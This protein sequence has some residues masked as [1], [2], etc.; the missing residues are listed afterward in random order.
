MERAGLGREPRAP[1][2]MWGPPA[3]GPMEAWPWQA[4]A[5]ATTYWGQGLGQ[6]D[7]TP[8]TTR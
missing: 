4:G 2:A 3:A 5:L 1:V 8:M 7:A 6:G